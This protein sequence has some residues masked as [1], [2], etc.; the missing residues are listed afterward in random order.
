MNKNKEEFEAEGYRSWFDMLMG[1]TECAEKT[2]EQF[3]EG[4]ARYIFVI[5]KLGKSKYQE[6]NLK[7]VD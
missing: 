6:R 4:M 7:L 5:R 3:K 2:L 1:Q